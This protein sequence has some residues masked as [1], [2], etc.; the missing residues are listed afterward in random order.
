VANFLTKTVD[1]LIRGLSRCTR[2]QLVRL[3]TIQSCLY[4]RTVRNHRVQMDSPVRS[5]ATRTAVA[6]RHL[7]TEIRPIKLAKGIRSINSLPK[8]ALDSGMLGEFKGRGYF[9][10][11]VQK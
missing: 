4:T 3:P 7:C 11:V 10:R 9:V 1:A 6:A 8:L 2:A 5:A